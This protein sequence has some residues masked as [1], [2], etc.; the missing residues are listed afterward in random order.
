MSG[1]VIFDFETWQGYGFAGEKFLNL[2]EV[3]LINVVIAEGV[4]EIANFKIRRH[5][6]PD[7]SAERTS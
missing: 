2:F 1:I 6:R 7:E 4:D 5:A 3:V